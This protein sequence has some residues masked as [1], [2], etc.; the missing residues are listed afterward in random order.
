MV[1][2]GE[3]VH[4]THTR[5]R[6][7]L[8]AIAVALATLVPVSVASAAIAPTIKLNQKAGTQAASTANLGLDLK[9]SPTAGDTVKD[10]SLALPAGLLANA[11]TDGGACIKTTKLLSACQI[12]SGSVS[13]TA[14]ILGLHIPLTLPASLDLVAPPTADDLAGLQLVVLGSALGTPADITVRPSG[15]TDGIGLDVAFHNIPNTYS[16]LGL[17]VPIS[18]TELN[19]TLDGLR[20]PSTCPATP[21]SL[22]VT[23]DSYKAPSVAAGA[24]APLTVTGC[25]SVPYA[26]AFTLTAAKDS[27]DPGVALT[28]SITQKANEAT[29]SS[30]SLAFPVNALQANVIG[31][32]NGNLLCTNPASGTCTTVGTVTVTSPLYPNPIVGSLYL[33]SPILTPSLDIV[34]SEPF[35]ITLAGSVDLAT[36]SVT[37]TGI[38]D[39]PLT[40][41]QVALTGGP[42]AV[43]AATCSPATGTADGT[44]I[45]QNGDKTVTS[46]PS[47]TVSGCTATAS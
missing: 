23:A 29:S 9:F 42:D 19:T 31:I 16:V 46:D 14:T 32:L 28:T 1:Q 17:A 37:F 45:N 43:Y 30:I 21:E 39:I 4:R 24:T 41:F 6:L 12:G 26:P 22:Q 34:L 5:V 35:P 2:G 38:P 36:N 40:D 25:S 20:Y 44:F 27:A 18:V 7:V 8:L 15:D 3:V 13:A 10:L 33:V 47:F 11:A